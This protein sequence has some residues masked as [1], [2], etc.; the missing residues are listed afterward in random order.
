MTDI[1]KLI[2]VIQKSNTDQTIKDI[3]I[4]DLLESGLTDFL[5]AQIE[6]YCDVYN[7]RQLIE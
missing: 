7:L 3:L 6:T 4:K 1:E 5:V 2:D